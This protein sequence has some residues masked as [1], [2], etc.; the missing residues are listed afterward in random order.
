M[1]ISVV[2]LAIVLVV[3]AALAITFG[4]LYA[5]EVRTKP[6]ATGEEAPVAP[7]PT[8]VPGGLSYTLRSAV[9]SPI[10]G[11]NLGFSV[12]YNDFARSGVAC[13]TTADSL[14]TARFFT[15]SDALELK[16]GGGPDVDGECAHL[17]TSHFDDRALLAI[18]TNLE[19]TDRFSSSS[20]V[21]SESSSAW[22]S[23][24]ANEDGV[25]V[26]DYGKIGADVYRAS[27]TTLGGVSG[28]RFDRL[29]SDGSWTVVSQ[30][31]DA[32]FPLG[33][34][35][36]T[37]GTFAGDEGVFIAGA[38]NGIL[39]F[40]FDGS[41]WSLQTQRTLFRGTAQ[42]LCNVSAQR[43][44]GELVYVARSQGLGGQPSSCQALYELYR[45]TGTRDAQLGAVSSF[46]S[47]CDSTT[48]FVPASVSAE[49]MSIIAVPDFQFSQVN[50]TVQLF[51]Y[52]VIATEPVQVA[53]GTPGDM[54]GNPAIFSLVTTI[55]SDTSS[56]TAVFRPAI[57]S[58]Q[59]LLITTSND[60]LVLYG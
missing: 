2:I 10:A 43:S 4:V 54:A 52:R 28:A 49:D 55:S 36:A 46:K 32:N 23:D 41:A 30:S 21:W 25:R 8:G 18:T 56:L 11:E 35:F 20:F 26:I 45:N 16:L 6:E 57:S 3:L 14:T 44:T 24:G 5:D 53:A 1:D 31:G 33:T 48:S 38:E 29:E 40:T 22:I 39:I 19:T 27:Q 34:T 12:V 50:M 13:G 60:E 59:G 51:L 42:Q 7:T 15:V 47:A 37:N 17:A 58:E 9:N